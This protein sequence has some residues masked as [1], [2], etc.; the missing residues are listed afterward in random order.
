ME[1]EGAFTTAWSARQTY[2]REPQAKMEE[3][4]CAENNVDVFNQGYVP[5]PEAMRPDF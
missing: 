5:P 2:N 1:D 4:I 3:A